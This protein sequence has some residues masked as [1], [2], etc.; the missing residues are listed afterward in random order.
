MKD[1]QIKDTRAKLGLDFYQSMCLPLLLQPNSSF[2]TPIFNL[3]ISL[4]WRSQPLHV[5]V[6]QL[7]AVTSLKTT[8][9]NMLQSAWS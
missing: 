1:P 2:V 8:T 7:L 4:L 9:F 6:E 3:N 5:G